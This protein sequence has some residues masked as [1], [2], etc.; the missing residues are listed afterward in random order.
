M[1]FTAF[2]TVVAAQFERMQQHDLFRVAVEKD[3]LWA[4]Y[5]GSFPEGTNPIFRER[6]EHDCSCCRQ[7]VKAMGDVVA[8]IDGRIETIWDGPAGEYDAVAQA[9]GALVRAHP[10][11]DRFLT[12]TRKVGTDKTFE[13]LMGQV[14][15]WDH[16][17]VNVDPRHVAPRDQIPTRL[18]EA[19]ST[20]DVVLRGLREI[21]DDAVDTVLDLI[22][23]RSLYRGDEHKGAVEGFKALKARFAALS[24]LEQEVLAWG[25]PFKIRSTVIGSLLVDLSEGRDLEGAVGS[26]EVKVAP[27]NYKRPTALVT[28]KMIEAA[29]TVVEALGLTSALDRRYAK[30][31]DITINNVLFADRST[32]ITG[33]AF[34]D[35]PTRAPAQS[36]D[37]VEEIPIERFL[38]EVLPR[39]ESIEALVEN[40]HANNLV[41]LIAP[42][43]PTAGRLFR[44][45]NNFSWSYAGEV[46]DAIKERVKKAG[47]SVS[48]DLCCRLAWS[49]F[50][51]LDFHMKEPGPYEIYYG[52][53]R[54]RSPSGGMLD[55]DM[56]AG[57]G[58]TREPVENIFYAHR[59]TM[60]PGLY[61]LLVHQYSARETTNVGFEVEIDYLGTIHRFAH[62][63]PMR[64]G[65]FVEV[66]Q[67]RVTPG[68]V[69]I[70]P[71][72]PSST[73]SRPMWGVP[74]ETFQKVNV[75][76]LSPNQWD[77]R[78]TGNRHYFFMLD[79]CQND[80]SARGFFNEFLDERLTEHR[81]VFELVGRK[82][83]VAPAADQLSGLGFSSTQRNAL[84]C[85]V[86]GSFN[87]TVRVTF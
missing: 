2:K 18:G 34:D 68:G 47:G 30:L 85:R 57:G 83:Q 73:A 32:R 7:F 53:K 49:N 27:T 62:A 31:P 29:K 87:R 24:P 12:D 33:G 4:T 65:N 54:T 25:T 51:D 75:M 64:T 60:R 35:L 76:M 40:R 45:D 42:V 55:V 3:T 67:L 23:Q 17:A 39:A 50:D 36:F 26:F 9:M 86:K 28:P 6:T 63:E 70:I 52:N 43:D 8:V 14:K 46:T 16:F 21:T 41:S 37:K 72:L 38:A 61:R 82:L 66:A 80:G 56:N 84:V 79:G 58:H 48:G 77:D 22:G 19:R 59:G 20:R 1:H 15:T 81:K 78:P 44:W 74:S 11:V 10:I 69:E 13:D 5:L 71:V